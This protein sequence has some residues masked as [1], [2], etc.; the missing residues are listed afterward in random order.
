ME[1]LD[2]YIRYLPT[3]KNSPKVTATTKKGNIPFEE[4]LI[5][6]RNPLFANRK[7]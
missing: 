7:L 5:Y 6:I 4:R 2:R 3:L 1:V